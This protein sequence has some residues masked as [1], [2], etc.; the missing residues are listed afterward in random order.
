M[1]LFFRRYGLLASVFITG[2]AVLIVEVTATRILSPFF[3]NTLYTFSSVIGVVLTALSLGYYIG[4]IV[5][6]KFPSEKLFFGII[7]ISGFSVFLLKLLI[8]SLLPTMGSSFSIV[9]GPLISSIILFFPPSFLLGMLSPYAIKLRQ[10]S[11]PKEGVGRVSGEVFFWS[12][13]GSIAGSIS[14]GFFLI[15]R[16]GLNQ[17]VITVGLVLVFLGVI[18]L[19]I[20]CEKNKKI[21]LI[22]IT[23]TA[24]ISLTQF[25]Q[26]D[27]N[28][29][30]SKDGIYE[31]ISIYDGVLDGRPT[32]FFQQDRSSSG[33][34]FLDSDE[35][36]YDY[37]KYYEL[38]KLTNPKPKHSLVLGGGAYSVPKAILK[39]LPVAT[40]DVVEIEPSLFNLAK[41]YFRLSETQ[42][43]KNYVEDGR[44]FLQNSS[45]KYDLI[46]S[47]VYYSFYS[48]PVHF[49]TKDFF[50]LAKK[51]LSRD[52]VFV[53]NFIG[54]LRADKN[55]LTH[56]LMK[57]F[58][59]VFSNS[60]FFALDSTSYK[61]AQNIIFLGINSDKKINFDDSKIKA[62]RQKIISDLKSRLIDVDY[63]ELKS[64][65]VLT[66][67]Y[68]PIEYLTAQLIKRD[69]ERTIA[70]FNANRA[71]SYIRQQ[72]SF[73][74]RH[75]RAQGHKRTQEFLISELKKLSDDVV[76]Q[77]WNHQSTDG[78][79]DALKNIIGRFNPQE[80]KRIILGSHYDT[81]R[82]AVKDEKSPEDLVPGAND[83]ASG[84]ALLL[85]IAQF[86]SNTDLPPRAGVDIVFFDGE[87][88]EEDL[89]KKD[90]TPLG[91]QHFAKEVDTIYPNKKPIIGIVVDMICD[92][93]LNI[94]MEENS[95]DYANRQVK[96]FWK[97]ASRNWPFYFF[98]KTK[99]RIFDDHSSLYSVG[100]PSFLI[101]D[102][103]YPYFHTTQDTVDKCSEKSLKIVG[104]SILL[105]IYSL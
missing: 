55:S 20:S 78:E 52:G 29:L 61:K 75:L 87:E 21:I 26:S 85:E 77:K 93:D 76:I 43:L 8:Y 27:K 95:L 34:M 96:D 28:F 68:A 71:M 37:T 59:S 80:E 57:T 36:V 102:F 66:D 25:I 67:N 49:T 15:P 40:V 91:S 104:D 73:G 18:G 88:G 100:I 81:K 10:I 35:L 38:Y 50:S 65:P 17:I 19:L 32:R 4:G 47:D 103:D 46:F 72:L 16:F 105:Y 70:I 51:K 24:L 53:A 13:L 84:V 60:Y 69:L 9:S 89:S 30:Y 64:Y 83:G 5:S 41:K 33:A 22:I 101:I 7:L 56:S 92:R 99:Y 3:G 42:R 45:K 82:F 90:W 1:K 23:L 74:P 31:K 39:N 11:M 86:L 79:I 94:F 44:R 14:S 98:E 48:V 2:A 6:D 97:I 54:D 58:R 12:T 63:R 62:H